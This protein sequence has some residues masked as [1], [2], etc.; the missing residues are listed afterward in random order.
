MLAEEDA[1]ESLT[2]EQLEEL[3]LMAPS[4]QSLLIPLLKENAIPWPE[5]GYEAV[6]TSGQCVAAMLEVAWPD[7]KVGIVL[8]EEDAAPFE[9]EGWTVIQSEGLSS[10][11]LKESLT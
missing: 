11:T 8:P 7:Q 3:T 6:S 5:I 4:L 10:E 9:A 1:T 2:P